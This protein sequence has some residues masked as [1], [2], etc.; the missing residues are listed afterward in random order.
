MHTLLL[1]TDHR[2]YSWGYNAYGQI[3]DGTVQNR[4]TSMTKIMDNVISIAAGVSSSLV[5]TENGELYSWGRNNGKQQATDATGNVLKP[6]KIAIFENPFSH[7]EFHDEITN[8]FLNETTQLTG[9]VYNAAP[10][11]A[12]WTSSNENIVTVDQYGNITALGIGT[13]NITFTTKDGLSDTC[14]ISVKQKNINY[15]RDGNTELSFKQVAARGYHALALTTDGK[16]FA[17][18]MNDTG[19]IGDGT[20]GHK[21]TPTYVMDDVVSMSAGGNHNMVVTTNGDLYVW[22]GNENNQL[23]DGTTTARLTPVK[24]LENIKSVE[25]SNHTSMA[26]TTNDDLYVWGWNAYGQVGDG[27]IVNR[28]RPVKIFSNVKM[29]ASGNGYVFALTNNDELYSWGLN[30]VGQLGNNSTC[31]SSV[32]V[33]IMDNVKYVSAG[34]KCSYAITN[35]NV[36][37]GWGM[38]HNGQLLGVAGNKKLKPTVLSINK[39]ILSLKNFTHTMLLDTDHHLYSWG[40]NGSGQIG[41]GTVTHRNTSMPKIMDNVIS[42]AAGAHS[43]LAVTESGELY[44]WG[45]NCFRQQA[46]DETKD[47]LAPTKIPIYGDSIPRVELTNAQ[48]SLG[49]NDSTQLTGTVYN[50]PPTEATWTSSDNNIVTVDKY[51]NISAVGIGTAQITF[52]NESGLTDTCV[53]TVVN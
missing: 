11:E 31:N 46:T 13:A 35:N 19:E 27:T 7:M 53:I 15:V 51:G 41:D 20:L 12:T 6:K 18:G 32:P 3:G 10:A 25:A 36:V 9:T 42:I 40:Y 48:I 39:S 49:V 38:N 37:Y 22:G 23:G 45:S 5:V 33:K 44:S 16:V 1:D 8:L 21:S 50:A 14:M 47:I 34:Y 29:V 52:T 17:W 43:S 26:I 24:I 28:A 30:N 4:S 2:L